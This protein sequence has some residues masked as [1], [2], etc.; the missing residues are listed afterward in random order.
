VTSQ[1][2]DGAPAT[3]EDDPSSAWP[4]TDDDLCRRFEAVP[5]A[6]IND[7][8]RTRG[9]LRRVLPPSIVELQ[10]GRRVAGIVFTIS[11]AVSTELRGE[12]EERAQMLEAIRPNS[13]CVWETGGD[14]ESAQWGEIMTMAA[15]KRGCRGA[16]I[17]GGI[18]DADRILDLDFPVFSRYRTSN[19]MLGRFRLTHWQRPVAIGGVEIVPG[20]VIVGDIDG[21]IVVPQ[22]LAF[23][24]LVEAERI[25]ENEVEFK[26]MIL[27][28]VSPRDVVARGGYF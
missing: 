16:V 28:G 3:D 21:V 24:V 18:R 13:V 20:D 8:L 25:V 23:E 10:S 12:M 27:S 19:G 7:V 2:T 14:E 22:A 9:L 17:D 15:M 6:A 26:E 5:T 1:T 4:I 11:G